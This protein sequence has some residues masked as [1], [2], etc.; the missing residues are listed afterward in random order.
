M[1]S[2]WIRTP[3]LLLCILMVASTI[4]FARVVY[5][6]NPEGLG[7]VL[8]SGLNGLKAYFEWLLDVLL[9]VW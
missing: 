7:Q 4:L 5:G 9:I 1:K 6:A 3:I 2:W 8:A